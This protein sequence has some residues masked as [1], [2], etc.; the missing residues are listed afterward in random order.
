MDVKKWLVTRMKYMRSGSF[1]D[2]ADTVALG[3]HSDPIIQR[4]EQPAS[5]DV[6]EMKTERT[7]N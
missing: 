3:R 1:S 6:V 5:T 7:A 2:V 4:E